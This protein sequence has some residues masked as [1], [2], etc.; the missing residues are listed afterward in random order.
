MDPAG[1]DDPASDRGDEFTPAGSD[2]PETV[3]PQA[4]AD[5]GAQGAEPKPEAPDAETAAKEGDEAKPRKG[6]GVIPVDR[7]EAILARE[8]V[9]QANVTS[10]WSYGF[11]GSA[12]PV[13]PIR[14]LFLYVKY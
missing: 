8:R 4:T 13:L 5:A 3:A 9:A 10:G 11:H 7:H 2:A 14:F 6:R 12:I 1:D